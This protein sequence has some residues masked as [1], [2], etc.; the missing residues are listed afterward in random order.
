MSFLDIEPKI[1]IFK[2]NFLY[3]NLSQLLFDV[4]NLFLN[5]SKDKFKTLLQYKKEFGLC[6]KLFFTNGI[7]A[8]YRLIVE[9][10]KFEFYDISKEDYKERLKE[11][12]IRS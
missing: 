1:I 8:D 9:E 10:N 7:S 5:V 3:T 2:D 11:Y 6:K 4:K 12:V